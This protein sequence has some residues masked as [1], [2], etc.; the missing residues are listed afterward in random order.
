MKS[1]LGNR[2]SNVNK[3]STLKLNPH[4][5]AIIRQISSTEAMTG[6]GLWSPLHPWLRDIVKYGAFVEATY[7]AFD[8]DPLSE[9]VLYLE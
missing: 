6:M 1:H 7:D 4:D 8:F 9:V 5:M 2:L 3:L